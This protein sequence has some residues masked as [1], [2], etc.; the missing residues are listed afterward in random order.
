MYGCRDIFHLRKYG[1]DG[2]VIY[3]LMMIRCW[4]LVTLPYV[5]VA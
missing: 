4:G 5:Q 3:T 2:H 1:E